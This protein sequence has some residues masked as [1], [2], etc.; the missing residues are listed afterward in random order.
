MSGADNN[1]GRLRR[2]HDSHCGTS[3]GYMH[4]VHGRHVVPQ[5][6]YHDNIS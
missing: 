3:V 4:V 1:R 6:D 2:Y 5:Y